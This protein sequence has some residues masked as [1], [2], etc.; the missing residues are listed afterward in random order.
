VVLIVVLIVVLLGIS[1]LSQKHASTTPAGFPRSVAT[2]MPTPAPTPTNA[3]LATSVRQQLDE[4]KTPTGTPTDKIGIVARMAVFAALS[5][6]TVEARQRHDPTLT[7]LAEALDTQL[8]RTQSREFPKLRKSWATFMNGVGWEHNL[9]VDAK[10]DR[11]QTLVL[12][13]G[14]FANNHAIKVSMEDLNETL[15]LLRFNRVEYHWADSPDIKYTYYELHPPSDGDAI[16]A[17]STF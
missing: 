8:V 10:G 9:T 6:L 13:C 16:Q 12:T 17:V 11:N 3:E 7:N 5:H 4:L 14:V 2:P 1:S 15:H